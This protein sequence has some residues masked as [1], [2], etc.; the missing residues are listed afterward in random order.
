MAPISY[1]IDLEWGESLVSLRMAVPRSLWLGY[2]GTELSLGK[3][4]KFDAAASPPFLLEVNDEPGD[5]Y[6]M[7]YDAVLA[8]V[9]VEHSTFGSFHLPNTM[10]EEHSSNNTVFVGRRGPGRRRRSRKRR[11]VRAQASSPIPALTSRAD[12]DSDDSSGNEDNRDDDND[13]VPRLPQ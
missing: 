12:S 9:Q 8:Y 1:A 10:P 2:T 11:R 6:A 3:I 4:A 5:L 7:R 13:S